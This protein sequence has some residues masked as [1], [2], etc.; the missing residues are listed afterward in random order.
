MIIARHTSRRPAVARL[1]VATA[2]LVLAPAA[3]GAQTLSPPPETEDRPMLQVG[4][5]EVRP[6]VLLTNFGV[7][8]NVFNE[9]DNPKQDFTFTLSPDVELAVKPGRL[10]LALTG[11]SDFVYYEKYTSERSVN[12]HVLGNVEADLGNIRPFLTLSANHTSARANGEID[13]RGRH[14]PRS[15][16]AGSTVRTTS[17]TSV[18]FTYRRAIEQFDEGTI[19]RGQ[20]VSQTLNNTTSIYEGAFYVDLT[21][22]TTFALVVSEEQMRF[23]S[24][25]VRDSNTFRIAPTF[26]FSPSGV[27]NGTASVG[28]RRLKGR[29]ASLEDYNGL[30]AVGTLGAAIADR[31]KIDTIFTH[32]VRYSYEEA[33]P[34]YVLSGGRVSLTTIL[35]GGFDVRFKAGRELMNYRALAGNADPGKDAVVIYGPGFGY[36]VTPRALLV[37]EAEFTDRNSTR[38]ASREYDNH[39]IFAT[40]TWGATR[41]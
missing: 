21:A 6:R 24:E 41:R 1:L 13:V 40:L 16:A 32:D 17:K 35:A 30:V 37:V 10:R 15:L 12:R 27:L 4:P 19:F 36:Q 11:G 14:H 7:D 5:V 26:S 2:S 34:Y 23:D 20:D 22:L 29:E 18:G 39:R 9:H 25:T 28:Y 38:D 3:A 8:N 33:L 31:Y